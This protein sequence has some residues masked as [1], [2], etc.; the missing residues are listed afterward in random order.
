MKHA[1]C[2]QLNASFE[3]MTL[4]PMKAAI[5]LLIQGKAEI[6]EADELSGV[7][8]ERMVHARPLVIRLK[9]FIKVPRRFRRKVSNTFLFARDEY[10]C[11]YCGRHE[12]NLKDREFLNRDHVQPES[13]GGETSWANCVTACSSC[14]SKKDDKTP[15]EAGLVLRK[16]P[17]E[18][19]LVH[20]KWSVRSLTPMQARYIELFYGAAAVKQLKR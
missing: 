5:R 3:P 18:P 20:L 11:Q 4:V 1:P 16:V 10:S 12:R 8:S 19:H 6:V 14:N 13:R 7:R 9:K 17:S 15:Q 2:L